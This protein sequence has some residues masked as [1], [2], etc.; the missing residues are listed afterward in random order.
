MDYK[1]AR[2]VLQME[3][4]VGVTRLLIVDDHPLVRSGI[5]ALITMEEGLELVAHLLLLLSAVM[6]GWRTSP[7]LDDPN[8][9]TPKSPAK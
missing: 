2:K 8:R 5:K 1:G 6:G 9:P 3:K 7:R 4:G